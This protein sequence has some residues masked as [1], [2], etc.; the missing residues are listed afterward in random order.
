MAEGNKF[1]K[2]MVGNAHGAWLHGDKMDYALD[3]EQLWVAQLEP[4]L[5][6]AGDKVKRMRR[7]CL[8]L[9]LNLFYR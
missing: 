5:K 6:A 8:S 7:I 9:K 1:M 4:L 3:Y 2:D